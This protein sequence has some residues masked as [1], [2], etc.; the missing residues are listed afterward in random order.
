MQQQLHELNE[1]HK[2]DRQILEYD[3]L[4][5]LYKEACKARDRAVEDCRDLE[6]EWCDHEQ[7]LGQQMSRVRK[8]VNALQ[9][10]EDN[11]CVQARSAD[12]FRDWLRVEEEFN[13][14]RRK[15]RPDCEYYSWLRVI[16]RKKMICDAQYAAYQQAIRSASSAIKERQARCAAVNKRCD[17]LISRLPDGE[18]LS[19]VIPINE[20]EDEDQFEEDQMEQ[21]RPINERAQETQKKLREGAMKRRYGHES[22]IK[23][24]SKEIKQCSKE[25]NVLTEEC[26]DIL[27]EIRE[28]TARLEI[29]VSFEE[30]IK[31][32][33]DIEKQISHK[34]EEYRRMKVQLRQ[35][36]SAELAQLE[37][38][39]KRRARKLDDDHE[40][41][42][43]SLHADI[44]KAS[45]VLAAMKKNIQGKS[46]DD[47]GVESVRSWSQRLRKRDSVRST[48]EPMSEMSMSEAKSIKSELKAADAAKAARVMDISIATES[49]WGEKLTEEIE[50][51]RTAKKQIDEFNEKMYGGRQEFNEKGG[52]SVIGQKPN[53][54]SLKHEA[55]RQLKE[56]HSARMDMLKL[57]YNELLKKVRDGAQ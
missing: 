23:S 53:R 26:E 34:K 11:N 6:K 14:S 22:E 9:D 37:R 52:N 1:L 12:R 55:L 46:G 18:L 8:A 20:N 38:E 48:R 50:R 41:E 17:R 27:D 31:E 3:Q 43:A 40:A 45:D 7:F 32:K 44:A 42:R 49:L 24:L 57:E 10:D 29:G 5:I 21:R 13:N 39:S 15:A 19:W 47:E 51:H 36:P 33:R 54:E 28:K 30:A 56:T 2:Q 4:S 25:L 16:E 35:G